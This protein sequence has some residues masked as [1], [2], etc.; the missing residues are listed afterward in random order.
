MI[1]PG[2]VQTV[3]YPQ[4]DFTKAKRVYQHESL[5]YANSYTASATI[6]INYRVFNRI[7][8]VVLVVA[9]EKRFPISDNDKK[10]N[11]GLQLK[12]PKQVRG[13]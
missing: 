4:P 10:V 5:E 6:G 1:S 8:G 7:T 11:I 12:Y 3:S 13:S 2:L 9:G